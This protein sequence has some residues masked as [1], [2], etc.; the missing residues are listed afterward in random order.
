V[1]YHFLDGHPTR[2]PPTL[3]AVR[4]KWKTYQKRLWYLFTSFC[5]GK[6]RTLSHDDKSNERTKIA[7][8]VYTV[9]G[10][11]TGRM[12]TIERNGKA[13]KRPVLLLPASLKNVQL[14]GPCWKNISSLL[15]YVIRCARCPTMTNEWTYK[16]S[17]KRAYV[18]GCRWPWTW[19][20]SAA[21]E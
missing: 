17:K 12:V 18:K 8:Q 16:T 1:L 10:I 9:S 21:K 20:Y 7:K 13:E 4:N 19:R 2:R 6:L 14:Q 3:T 11:Q 5:C 15:T